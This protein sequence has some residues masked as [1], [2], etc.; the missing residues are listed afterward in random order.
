[1][2]LM[3]LV[4]L[5][6]ILFA[7]CGV[8]DAVL[9]QDKIEPPFRRRIVGGEPTDIKEHP[10]QV[11]LQF[12]GT[13]FCGGSIIAQK[14][15]LTAA[16][17]FEFSIANNDWGAKAGATNYATS[18]SWAQVERA[19]VH[20]EYKGR[21]TFEND[22]ALMKLTAP[23]AA[24]RAVPLAS[25]SMTIPLSQPLEVTGW[26]AT[27]DG[28]SGA[29]VLRKGIVPYV[30]SGV[31]NEP[32]SYNG[33]IKDGMMCAG[34]REGGVDSCQGDSGGPLVWRTT[35]GPVLVGVVSFGDGCAL[36]LKYGVYSRVSAY[37]D[38]IDRTLAADRN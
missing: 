29:D 35:D 4:G 27:S 30:A 24:G 3:R 6:A 17:C 13:F 25:A 12:R 10:W 2:R 9:A 33:R 32:A 18:G 14:W 21:P 1:M 26:G 16:H 36:K 22:L 19:V 37:R 5:A 31:C 34:L 11:A 15:I 38:W 7:S 8:T 28:G 20:P 23:A